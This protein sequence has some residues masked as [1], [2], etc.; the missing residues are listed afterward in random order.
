MNHVLHCLVRLKT[1][2]TELLDHSWADQPEKLLGGKRKKKKKVNK[3]ANTLLHGALWTF[4][5][6]AMTPRLTS[7]L[8]RDCT[9]CRFINST[10][11]PGLLHLPWAVYSWWNSSQLPHFHGILRW[12]CER[13]FEIPVPIHINF[14]FFA[15]HYTI[16]SLQRYKHIFKK[17][18]ALT[19]LCGLKCNSCRETDQANT[20]HVQHRN[21]VSLLFWIQWVVKARTDTPEP[22][23]FLFPMGRLEAV[24]LD[25]LCRSTHK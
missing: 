23:Q 22:R 19:S 11:Q 1:L 8:S 12:Y 21:S 4:Q 3:Q 16:L 14:F 9:S 7:V 20:R 24:Q 6:T 5:M 10:W 13:V 25:T 15:S 17:N 2:H 18:G